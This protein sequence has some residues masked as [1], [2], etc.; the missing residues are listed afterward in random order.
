VARKQVAKRRRK[1]FDSLAVLVVWS[2]WL[3]RNDRAF[4]RR[5]LTDDQLVGQALA[6]A[7]QW[8]LAGLIDRSKLVGD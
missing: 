7:E 5:V 2:I 3:H 1:A 6:N 8:C 4:G